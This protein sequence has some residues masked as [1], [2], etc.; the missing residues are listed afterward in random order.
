MAS[1]TLFLVPLHKSL[2]AASRPC[3]AKLPM[4]MRTY[5]RLRYATTREPSI[6]R[7][8]FPSGT[9][10]TIFLFFFLAIPS[11]RFHVLVLTKTPPPRPYPLSAPRQGTT[12]ADAAVAADTVNARSRTAADANGTRR[13]HNPGRRRALCRRRGDC[14][15]V[16]AGELD[17]GTAVAVDVADGAA[18]DGVAKDV[19]VAVVAAVVEAVVGDAL[20]VAAVAAVDVA[21]DDKAASHGPV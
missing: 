18:E 15:G 20:G 21:D 7:S 4:Q 9:Y 19:V 14:A 1:G 11:L 12:A 10:L 5:P 2:Y 16:V 13:R 8:P 17:L 3:F 6:V